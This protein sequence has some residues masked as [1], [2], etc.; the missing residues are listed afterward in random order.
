MGH[1]IVYCFKCQTRIVGTDFDKG[2]AFETGLHVVCLKCA[3][4]LL[5]TL[6]ADR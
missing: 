5:P 1:Q 6:P 3:V 4:V 2:K